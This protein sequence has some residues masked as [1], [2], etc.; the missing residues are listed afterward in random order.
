MVPQNPAGTA[1]LR[2]SGGENAAV[3]PSV[4]QLGGKCENGKPSRRPL[5]QLRP[6]KPP[7]VAK[8]ALIREQ[9]SRD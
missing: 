2:K 3:K 9:L 7:R 4:Y 1:C 6:P 5:K 8:H